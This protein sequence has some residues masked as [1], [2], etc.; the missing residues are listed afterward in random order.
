MCG[1]R[2]GS[3]DWLAEQK[4]WS[5]IRKWVR[6]ARNYLL[7]ERFLP[8]I[9]TIFPGDIEKRISEHFTV[10][11]HTEIYGVFKIKKPRTFLSGS[12]KCNWTRK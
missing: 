2:G 5:I 1:G 12:A 10:E 3:G 7:N 6:N 4:Y 9:W 8:E 11:V